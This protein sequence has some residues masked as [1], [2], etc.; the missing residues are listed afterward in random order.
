MTALVLVEAN[1]PPYTQDE[2]A[3][4]KCPRALAWVARPRQTSTQ[5]L[6]ECYT[7]RKRIGG[8]RLMAQE[9]AKRTVSCFAAKPPQECKELLR[10][11]QKIEECYRIRW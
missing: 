4:T 9:A 8:K 10:R 2:S 1:D 11:A 5:L 6:P 3:A 7:N